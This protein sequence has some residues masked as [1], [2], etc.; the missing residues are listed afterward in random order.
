MQKCNPYAEEGPKQ[1]PH[2][3]GG[4]QLQ[5]QREGV[6]R[7]TPHTRHRSLT[8]RLEKKS[9]PEVGRRKEPAEEW[10]YYDGSVTVT[11]CRNV[12]HWNTEGLIAIY[13]RKTDYNESDYKEDR[14]D[15]IIYN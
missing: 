14:E 8:K 1:R 3:Q 4:R 12:E 10:I 7:P 5:D 2:R 9:E 11:N 13:R 6:Q 15:K